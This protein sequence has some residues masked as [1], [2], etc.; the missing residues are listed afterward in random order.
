MLANWD[1]L[2]KS[3][4]IMHDRYAVLWNRNYRTC[5]LI[6]YILFSESDY[7]FETCVKFLQNSVE[8]DGYQNNSVLRT[9]FGGSAILLSYV[10]QVFSDHHIWNKHLELAELHNTSPDKY[11]PS[12]RGV[13]LSRL[14]LTYL[15]NKGPAYLTELYD[16][17]CK[18]GLVSIEVL[19]HCLS[20]LLARENSGVWRR[21]IYYANDCILSVKAEDINKELYDEC[22]ESKHDFAFQIC[23]SGR[24]YVERLMSEFEFFSNRLSNKNKPLYMNGDIRKLR[25]I[26][27]NVFN[28]VRNCCR[29]MICFMNEYMRLTNMK[30]EQYLRLQIHPKTSNG[31]YQLHTE[32]IIFSHIAYLNKTRL[33]FL[34]RDV[35]ADFDTRKRYNEL[36]VD[37]ISKYLKLYNDYIAPISKARSKVYEELFGIVSAIQNDM[38]K[39]KHDSNILFQSIDLPKKHR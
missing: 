5:S 33:F 31:S 38:N 37:Y 17:F 29:N 14:I 19:C 20:I 18:N 25:V 10:C 11:S 27:N 36:F 26:M 12:S 39:G 3:L 8:D 4:E 9:Y 1:K 22:H 6:A 30:K 16:V 15:Y 24:A 35:A 13:S 2:N 23:D 21:P 32:R 7:E 34:N 28:A